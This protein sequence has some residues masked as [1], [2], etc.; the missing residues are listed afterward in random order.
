MQKKL[1]NIESKETLP[2]IEK[3]RP[4]KLDDVISHSI[5]V[6]TLNNFINNNEL[7]HLL[8][9]GPAGTGKTSAIMAV[10]RT[11][12]KENYDVMTMEINASEERGIEV[13]RNRIMQ[14]ANSKSM[15]FENQSSA[16]FKLIILDEADAMTLDAQASLRRVIEK[17]TNNVRFCL[18]CNYIKKIDVA[19]QSRCTCFRFAPLKMNYV[20]QKV[21]EILGK[22]KIKYTMG[23]VDTVVKRSNGDMRKVLNVLQSVSMAYDSIDEKNVDKCLGYPHK[24]D[25]VNILR[26]LVN[27][28]F[29]N[30]Y[31]ILKEYK[32][33][34]GYSL[35]DI[36][37]EV[38]DYLIEKLM[39]KNFNN[40]DEKIN[41]SEEKIMNIL[42]HLAKIEYN[43]ANASDEIIQC[44]AF[45]SIFKVNHKHMAV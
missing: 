11:L 7:P 31:Y 9:H 20:K 5:I 40:K 34:N 8:F 14:F 6:E 41:L 30:A 42:K 45:V 24:K 12:Y 33:E 38:H 4:N 44:G 43:V 10:A 22:E 26:N 39:T 29:K 25:I 19:I 1:L 23:G 2:W 27:D 17:Y 36:M 35:T 32:E 13:V 16:P 37:V 28:D 15:L 3:Y 21:Y 18:I